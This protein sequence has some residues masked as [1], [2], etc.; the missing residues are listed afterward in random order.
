MRVLL[1][2]DVVSQAG[3]DFLRAKLPALKRERGVDVVIANGE[4]SAVGN[5]VLPK[6]ADFLFQS[7]VDVITGG[8]HSFK[9]REAYAYL[10]E[11]EGIV[12]PGNYPDSAPGRG[13]YLYDGGA[14]TLL[15][16]NLIGTSFL[17]PLESPFDAADRILREHPADY[18]VVDFHAEATGEKAALGYYLDGRVGAVIGTHTHVQTADERILPGGTGFLTDVGMTGP[19]ESALG[20]KP[21]CVI[22]RLRGKLPTRF[23]VDDQAP[24]RMDGV[25]LDF[26]KKGGPCGGIERVQ[27]F[28]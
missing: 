10:D 27:V 22:A 19:A 18:T 15:V 20:V 2:G 16:V 26:P 3:C 4:N 13:W 6:S 11:A 23:E 28:A 5:G 14:Y 7:G 12:R 21:E 24:C 8:N 1:L 9:R 17:E 25:L